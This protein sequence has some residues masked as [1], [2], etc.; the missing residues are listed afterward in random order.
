[1]VSID[2]FFENSIGRFD[3]NELINFYSDHKLVILGKIVGFTYRH[4]LFFALFLITIL[5]I[6]RLSNRS[7]WDFHFDTRVLILATVAVGFTRLLFFVFICG[8]ES[9]YL[10]EA[11]PW[12]E[13]YLMLCMLGGSSARNVDH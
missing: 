4:V 3:F 12:V 9:C 1:M 10:V 6:F 7:Q 8:L 2:R 11:L 13:C 5:A